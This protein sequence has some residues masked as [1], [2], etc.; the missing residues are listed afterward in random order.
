MNKRFRSAAPRFG[1]HILLPVAAIGFSV[2][3][4]AWAQGAGVKQPQQFSVPARF[5]R[6]AFDKACAA[7]H[8]DWGSGTDKGPPLIHRIYEPSHHADIAFTLAV[9]RGAR[10]HHWNFG[11]MP[12]Q[13]QVT[14]E[15]IR[16]IIRFVREVQEANGIR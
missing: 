5:G 12:P 1:L 4:I 6:I 8:G 13:P 11:D 9:Q 3:V 10:Q 2:S 14:P 16:A 15:E 7:C